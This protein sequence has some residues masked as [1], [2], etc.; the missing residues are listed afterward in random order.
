MARTGRPWPSTARSSG[1]MSLLVGM[2]RRGVGRA[3]ER[4]PEVVL[5]E[6]GVP[7]ENFNDT[8]HL[9]V[10]RAAGIRGVP[11]ELVPHPSQQI[12]RMSR[13]TGSSCPSR[14]GLS[15]H[16][17]GHLQ[18]LRSQRGCDPK[19]A[20]ARRTVQVPA[21]WRCRCPMLAWQSLRRSRSFRLQHKRALRSVP[22]ETR[23][24][25]PLEPSLLV[26]PRGPLHSSRETGPR[27]R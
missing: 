12:W 8:L 10:Q 4:Q 7:A 27:R 19:S 22:R 20:L 11:H 16:A 21:Q 24:R 2:I 1:D 18:R 13:S 3:P 5:T 9:K 17:P 23:K 14:P 6:R 25:A 26:G 15:P